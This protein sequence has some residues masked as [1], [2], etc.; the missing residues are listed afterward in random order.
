MQN[1]SFNPSWESR[2]SGTRSGFTYKLDHLQFQPLM[3]EP[4]LWNKALY[5]AAVALASSFNPSWESRPSGTLPGQ[6]HPVR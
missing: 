5:E 2:P 3:G 6:I 4:S 1:L